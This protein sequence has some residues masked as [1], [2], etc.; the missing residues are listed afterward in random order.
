MSYNQGEVS[1]RSHPA[2]LVLA[3]F[4]ICLYSVLLKQHVS[5]VFVGK[6]GLTRRFFACFLDFFAVVAVTLCISLI[7]PLTLEACRVG[8]FSWSFRRDYGIPTDPYVFFSSVP[9]TFLALIL[10]SAYPLTQG[11]QTVGDYVM[12]IKVRPPLD[13]DGRFTWTGAVRRV[14]YSCVG[15]CAWPYTL[16]MGV[17]QKGQTWYDRA[18]GCRVSLVKYKEDGA[19]AAS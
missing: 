2:L 9:L 10:Y 12:R 6:A 5:I 15:L 7:I 4:I 14:W 16:L 3:A 13:A 8:H 17:D 1:V 19:D 11:K 18:T